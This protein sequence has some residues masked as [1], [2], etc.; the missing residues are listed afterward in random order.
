MKDVLTI[1]SC[2]TN[3]LF[4]FQFGFYDADLDKDQ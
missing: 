2:S 3:K 1:N 4:W